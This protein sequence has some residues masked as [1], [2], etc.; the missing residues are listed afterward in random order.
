VERLAD[1]LCHLLMGKTHGSAWKKSLR[2]VIVIGTASV[3]V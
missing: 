3:L 2:C 1:P